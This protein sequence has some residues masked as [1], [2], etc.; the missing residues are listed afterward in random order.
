MVLGATIA[1]P[2]LLPLLAMPLLVVVV[3]VG[4]GGVDLTLSDFVLGLVFWPAVLLSPKPFSP[5]LRR[6]LW[7][8]VIYQA[9]TLLTVVANPYLANAVEWFH[10][11]LLISG[12]LIVGWAV[13]R[14]GYAK[15]GLTLFLLA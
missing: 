14:S 3:R 4:G 1:Q 15:S 8:N 11:W 12:A 2:A 7:L 9:A 10:A 5:E 13:G 6:L